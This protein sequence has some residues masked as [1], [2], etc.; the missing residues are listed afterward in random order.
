MSCVDLTGTHMIDKMAVRLSQ[1]FCSVLSHWTVTLMF[2]SQWLWGPKGAWAAER[3]WGLWLEA[4]KERSHA[5]IDWQLQP[6][7]MTVTREQTVSDKSSRLSLSNTPPSSDSPSVSVY[8][9]VQ[10][11]LWKCKNP[12]FHSLGLWWN[13][14]SRYNTSLYRNV[15]SFFF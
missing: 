10:Y 3:Q 4:V 13:A 14:F 6:V 2:I 8:G 7:P 1:L 9:Q 11:I 5:P 12:S 15:F